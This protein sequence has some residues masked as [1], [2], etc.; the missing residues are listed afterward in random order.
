MLCPVRERG[1]FVVPPADA[2]LSTQ[3]AR[4]RSLTSFTSRSL[5][6]RVPASP[7]PHTAISAHARAPWSGEIRTSVETAPRCL[8]CGGF[9]PLR[10]TRKAG[11][12]K[13]QAAGLE[14]PSV[15]QAQSPRSRG[16]SHICDHCKRYLSRFVQSLAMRGA[17]AS[18]NAANNKRKEKGS[19]MLLRS[20]RSH[21]ASNHPRGSSQDRGAP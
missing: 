7:P 18:G 5:R 3:S 15:L 19:R 21:A 13:K 2:R 9:V 16:L 1:A 6:V 20:L 11:A 12:K 8:E 4:A 17:Y 14:I 10:K